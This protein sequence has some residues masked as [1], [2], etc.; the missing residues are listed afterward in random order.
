MINKSLVINS[1]T[2]WLISNIVDNTV[3][4]VVDNYETARNHLI[5]K[6]YKQ[7]DDWYKHFIKNADE[8]VLIHEYCVHRKSPI[9]PVYQKT[10][11]KKTRRMINKKL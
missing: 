3:I 9:S 8:Q 1:R 6:G 11:A 4:L 10:T 2:V 7:S 5:N